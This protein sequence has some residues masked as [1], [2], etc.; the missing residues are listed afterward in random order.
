MY[1]IMISCL[2][3]GASPGPDGGA[4]RQDLRRVDPITITIIITTTNNNNDNNN[5]DNDND[6]NDTTDD[7]NNSYTNRVHYAPS[8]PCCS[9][10]YR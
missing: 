4:A 5:N 8:G 10:C 2:P 9:Y 3:V 7:I 1:Y 6:N